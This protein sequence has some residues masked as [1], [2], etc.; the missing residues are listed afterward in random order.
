MVMKRKT[1]EQRAAQRE[2]E[3]DAANERNLRIFKD[4]HYL[5]PIISKYSG[6]CPMC[7]VFIAKNH[8]W[9]MRLPE[10]MEPRYEFENDNDTDTWYSIDTGARVH[11]GED[12]ISTHAR[13]YVHHYCWD[14]AAAIQFAESMEVN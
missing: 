8:S 6:N 13:S 12:G 7:H 10:P 4:A 5:E 14:A 3:E 11:S 9:V 1:P 2:R